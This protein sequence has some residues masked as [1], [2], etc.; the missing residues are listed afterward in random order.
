MY[1]SEL[2]WKQLW[3]VSSYCNLVEEYDASMS[4]NI[5]PRCLHFITSDCLKKVI[6]NL[7]PILH[8]GL[9]AFEIGSVITYLMKSLNLI[10]DTSEVPPWLCKGRAILLEKV[11]RL[12]PKSTAPLH[13]STQFTNEE[14]LEI[15]CN[16]KA[17]AMTKCTEGSKEG[18][19]GKDQLLVKM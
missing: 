14:P 17:L 7:N 11:I 13:V 3:S 6:I 19:L 18:L 4:G 5:S 16:P 12:T 1:S 8:Q 15:V 9:M 2:F 10:L